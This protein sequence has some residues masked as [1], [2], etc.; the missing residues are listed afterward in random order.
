MSHHFMNFLMLTS[1]F[2]G[3]HIKLLWCHIVFWIRSSTLTPPYLGEEE[4]A[5]KL[6]L[7]VID[8]IKFTAGGKDDLLVLNTTVDILLQKEMHQK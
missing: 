7:E 4:E 1:E 8:T 6:Q 5:M 3:F 2:N